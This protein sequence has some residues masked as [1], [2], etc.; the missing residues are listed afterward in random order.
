MC[1]CVY[2]CIQQLNTVLA[3]WNQFTLKFIRVNYFLYNYMY[4]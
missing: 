4:I 2:V 3:P 1:V